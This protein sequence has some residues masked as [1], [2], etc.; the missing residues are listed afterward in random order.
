MKQPSGL[1]HQQSTGFTWTSWTGH[2]VEA[3]A[4]RR[5]DLPTVTA[6][7]TSADEFVARDG[8]RFSTR[9]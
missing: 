9:R 8:M 5:E 4:A 3:L 7:A 1:K 2:V 6:P